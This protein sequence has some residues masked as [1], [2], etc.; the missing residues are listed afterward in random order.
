MSACV[1]C[2]C[3]TFVAY[4][5]TTLSVFLQSQFY[6]GVNLQYQTILLTQHSKVDHSTSTSYRHS[7]H[8]ASTATGSNT[9][10]T[11][12]HARRAALEL[13]TYLFVAPFSEYC[14]SPV[15][16]LYTAIG[17]EE[18]WPQWWLVWLKLCDRAKATSLG[19]RSWFFSSPLASCVVSKS[20]Y[21]F[22]VIL[23]S[24]L[25]APCPAPFFLSRWRNWWIRGIFMVAMISAFVV[26]IH[27]GRIALSVLVRKGWEERE[28]GDVGGCPL[29]CFWQG[30]VFLCVC[31]TYLHTYVCTYVRIWCVI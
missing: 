31:A 15:I 18:S 23:F 24:R 22:A 26:L 4:K 11:G 9:G 5:Q 3:C 10:G 13:I 28:R 25:P 8:T 19:A 16:V 17:G 2:V 29:S 30:D 20:L 7:W 1:L 6:K 21:S 27:T 12:S 14:G